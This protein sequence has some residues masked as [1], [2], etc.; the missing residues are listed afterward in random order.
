[1]VDVAYDLDAIGAAGRV[2]TSLQI[3]TQGS[4]AN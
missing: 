1:V 2:D 3:T 4:I